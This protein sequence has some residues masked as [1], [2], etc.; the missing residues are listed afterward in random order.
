MT[1]E[2]LENRGMWV[3]EIVTLIEYRLEWRF[4]VTAGADMVVFLQVVMDPEDSGPLTLCRR[5]VIEN[6]AERADVIRT[7]FKALLAA[8]EH[9]CR[10][11]FKY[12]GHAIF[13]PHGDPDLYVDAIERVPT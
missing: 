1:A 5:W 4:R 9:E 12:R 8:E 13:G 3:N 10:E 7:A 11:R 2:Q 6:D